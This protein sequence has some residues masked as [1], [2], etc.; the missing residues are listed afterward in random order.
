[1]KKSNGKQIIEKTGEIFRQS[2]GAMLVTIGLL[3]LSTSEIAAQTSPC[4]PVPY[5][6][7]TRTS[8]PFINSGTNQNIGYSRMDIWRNSDVDH[9]I[10]LFVHLPAGTVLKAYFN[11]VEIATLNQISGGTANEYWSWEGQGMNPPIAAVGDTMSVTKDGQPYVTGTYRR[12]QYNYEE[13]A[14]YFQNGNSISSPCTLFRGNATSPTRAVTFFIAITYA[15]TAITKVSLNEPTLQPGLPGPEIANLPIAATGMSGTWFTARISS[16]PIILTENQFSLLRQGLLSVTTFTAN[17]PNGYSQAPLTTQGINAGGD[18]EGDGIADLA[19]FRPAES[20]WYVQY[21]ST[22]Q[23]QIVNFGLPND[24]IVTGDYDSDKKAD[25]ATFQ[26]DNP[27]YPGQ[28]VWQILKS[29]NNTLQTIRWGTSGDIPLNIN[30][31]RNNT[32]DLGVFRPSNGTWYI[33]RMGDIIKPIAA[34]FGGPTDIIIRWGTA[35]DQPLVG[36]FNNDG[37]DELIVFRPT[38]GNWYIFNTALNNYQIIRWGVNGDIPI[39]KDFDGDGKV[40]LTVYRPSTGTWYIRRS[41]DNSVLIRRFGSSEDIPVPA[42]FDKDSV[43][44]I[45]V[46]RPSNGNWYITRSSDNSLFAEH[47]GAIGD[48]PAVGQK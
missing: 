10:H 4:D 38:E 12:E 48:I 1:M 20:K 11:G 15:P 36:D 9:Y 3:L 28:G 35:G 26:T 19:V 44:D 37:I 17:N 29:T 23:V 42:D 46:F 24:K 18:F 2:L 39:A 43:A 8:V 21:S 45:A 31:D 14:G 33:R 27:N 16:T 34:E 22:K 7:V 47:F 6:T 5:M 32:S 13:V 25:I 40:D 30:S 41:L